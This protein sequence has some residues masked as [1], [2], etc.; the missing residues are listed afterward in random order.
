MNDSENKVAVIT[1]A[2]S[3]IGLA[4]AEHCIRKG[5]KVVM[6][7]IEA[8]A[9]NQAKNTINGSN[10]NILPVVT[11]VSNHDDVEALARKATE[12]FGKTDILFNNAGVAGGSSA[13][14]S[15]IND[16]KWVL[17]VN[18]WGYIN[19]I[20]TFVPIMLKHKT[21]SYIVNSSSISGLVT[22]HPDAPYHLTKHAIVALSE[23]L[24]HDL[25][26]QG[27]NIKVS[28]LCPGPVNTKL[29]D[30]A[31]NRPDSLKNE[32]VQTENN[33]QS[34]AM[35][36]KFRQML[37]TG[38]SP[39]EVADHVFKAIE[40]GKFYIITHP[41]MKFLAELRMNDIL[42]EHNPTLPPKPE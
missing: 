2:A 3:G 42:N 4:L 39:G 26:I 17:G 41:E 21:E 5:M 6:A 25:A 18:L 28:V 10:T 9:L 16:W 24:Y 14:E 19:C 31:R 8:D 33:Q 27:A 15:T 35:E 34:D 32:H 29:M 11:D 38:M 1:G 12:N 22:Y 30:A 13:W 7:D 20:R 40:D 37:N 23:Q 36:E